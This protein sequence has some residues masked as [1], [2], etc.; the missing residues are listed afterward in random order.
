MENTSKV[1]VTDI[2]EHFGQK[3]QINMV[4]YRSNIRQ[5]DR[6]FDIQL[7]KFELFFEKAIHFLQ[8]SNDL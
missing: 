7:T 4:A 3:T 1:M 2:C 5:K 8:P 6:H